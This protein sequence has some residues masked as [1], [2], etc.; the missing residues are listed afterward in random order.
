MCHILSQQVEKKSL[1]GAHRSEVHLLFSLRAQCNHMGPEAM[2]A[3]ANLVTQVPTIEEVYLSGN[4]IKDKGLESLLFGLENCNR[5]VAV[6]QLRLLHLENCGIS[7]DG[8]RNLSV[9]LET[10]EFP[11]V[12]FVAGNEVPRGC[13]VV[14]SKGSRPYEQDAP[15]VLKL[16]DPLRETTLVHCLVKYYNRILLNPKTSKWRKISLIRACRYS[17][18]Q[19]QPDAQ[20]VFR[21]NL[22]AC[23]FNEGPKSKVKGDT[24]LLPER[25]GDNWDGIVWTNEFAQNIKFNADVRVQSAMFAL[26]HDLLIRVGTPYTGTIE[27]ECIFEE[28]RNNKKV[29]DAMNLSHVD[30]SKFEERFG[31]VD[32]KQRNGVIFVQEFIEY[33]AA[34]RYTLL[35]FQKIFG[36]YADAKGEVTQ[37]QMYKAL[38][39]DPE[40]RKYFGIKQ[41]HYKQF[42]E[43]FKS[44]TNDSSAGIKSRRK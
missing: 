36:K 44:L 29:R 9:F 8:F 6:P 10:Y 23:G 2:S 22:V 15:N 33:A 42:K 30:Y 12:V 21:Q 17:S 27:K 26:F 19:E 7:L 28:L 24:W 38:Q 20:R 13:T 31:S 5:D 16:P 43:L 35:Q 1:F 32:T 3:M 39:K 41:F 37:K 25:K 34:F 11:L 40:V 14:V 18:K 4:P